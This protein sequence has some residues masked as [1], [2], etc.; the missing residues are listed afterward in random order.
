MLLASVTMLEASAS[1]DPV[2]PVCGPSGSH[3]L[4]LTAPSDVLTGE[5]TITVTNSPNAGKVIFTWLP[6]GKRTAT[7]LQTSFVSNPSRPQ[8]YTF[9]WPTDKYPDGAGLLRAQYASTANEIVQISVTLSNGNAAGQFRH[10]AT[11]WAPP[12]PWAGTV[13]PVIA[14][15]GD[16][17]SNEKPSNAVIDAIVKT[18]PALFFYLGDV[19]EEGTFTELRNHYGLS[20]VDDPAGIGTLWGRLASI[21]MAT[22]GNHETHNQS[23]FFD[24]WHRSPTPGWLSF[25]FGGVQFFD[26]WSAG[27]KFDVGSAQYNDVQAQLAALAPNTCVVAFW[28]RPVVIGTQIRNT[29][30]PMWQLLANNGGDLVLNGD[31]HYMAEYRPLDAN[32]DPTTP[33]AHMVELLSGAGGHTLSPAKVDAARMVWPTTALKQSGAAYLTL[34][35]AANG[36]TATSVSWAFTTPAGATLQSGTV[37]C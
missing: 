28:H 20:D 24:Y 18:D 23:A 27:T 2:G 11:D 15:V 32:L 14:A 7:Y 31:A 16:G 21:T 19:Y 13:D 3:T 6:A 12:A 4:C 30:L 36:G 17:A 35:G 5:Q 37:S 25:Q 33:E 10:N 9:V 29:L 8:N 1:A 34:N 26:L 22:A